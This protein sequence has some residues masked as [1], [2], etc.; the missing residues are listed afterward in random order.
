MATPDRRPAC[1][2]PTS[3]PPA[4]PREAGRRY[5][6]ASEVIADELR[7]RIACGDLV[8]GDLL[9]NEKSLQEEFDVSRPTL[10]EA[11]RILEAE[12]LLVTSRGG[13]KGS[14][15]TLPSAR[16]A[17]RYA[18][19]IL[20]VRGATI[21]DIFALRTLVE[22]AAARLIA[23]REPR[24]DLGELR[25]LL[26]EMGEARANP[27][28]VARKLHAFD[29]ALLAL[30]GNEA[31]N[32]VGQMMA[33]ILSLHLHTIPETV[34]ALPEANARGI[35]QGPGPLYEMLDAIAQGNG[36]LAEQ[37]MRTR[38]LQNEDWHRRRMTERLNLAQS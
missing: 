38:T 5:R 16:H 37:L 24:P 34:A 35:A 13:P 11:M 31:L 21:S 20:Q 8:D 33:H 26:D 23:E 1:A 18:G 10:R 29:Q 28:E 14:R 9:P 25:R 36:A 30:S 7:A 15:V 12:G 3:P 22:P 17:A 19:L 4:P 2:L 6:K 27:R 32:L